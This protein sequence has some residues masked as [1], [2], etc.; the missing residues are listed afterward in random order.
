MTTDYK[1]FCYRYWLESRTR[2]LIALVLMILILL[3]ALSQAG[4]TI[5]NHP[6]LFGG[7]DL[8]FTQ[9]VWVIIYKG[10][11]LTIFTLASFLFGVG[12][13][14]QERAAGTALF[15]LSLPVQ[16]KLLVYSK[17]LT[18]SLEVVG[19]SLLFGFIIPLLSKM[20]GFDYPLKDALL[21][22][23]LI[24]TGGIVFM[25]LGFVLSLLITKET[26][27]IPLGVAFMSILFFITKMPVLKNLNIFNFM[28]GAGYLGNDN[29]LFNQPINVLGVVLVCSMLLIVSFVLVNAFKCIDT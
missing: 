22:S 20:F 4:E 7:R 5:K 10:Y 25:F 3:Q 6:Q 15:T 23:V 28:V 13:L 26:V 21:F 29:F 27:I 17:L 16:R 24:A 12:G 2:L 19:L 18:A 8:L 11:F 1:M 14:V 9:Y